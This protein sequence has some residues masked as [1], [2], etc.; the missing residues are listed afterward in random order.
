M[1]DFLSKLR[2]ICIT[3]G[4]ALKTAGIAAWSF[5]KT[6]FGITVTILS[7]LTITSTVMLSVRLYDFVHVDDKEIG[8][9][10]GLEVGLDLFAVKYQNQTG[11]ITVEGTDGEQVVAPGTSVEYTLRFRNKD[12]TA[13][14]YQL[15]S[16]VQ[17]LTE[18]ELPLMVRLIDPDEKYV[19]GSPTEWASIAE[20]NSVSLTDTL[21]AGDSAEYVFQWKWD[22]EGD[23][24]YDTLLGNTATEKPIEVEVSMSVY[25][26]ANTDI[27]LNGGFM[28]SGLGEIVFTAVVV[29][30]LGGSVALLITP[31]LRKKY[32]AKKAAK[33]SKS[34]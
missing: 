6:P 28:K 29:A 13:L 7:M 2:S 27:G 17:F 12:T 18:Y 4:K 11:E 19:L 34:E 32:L 22:Y 24:S 8:L 20:L 14:D 3:V 16:G 25:A 30:G 21:I 33:S 9:H 1:S 10:S 5:L 23:D 15:T 31:P 26:A